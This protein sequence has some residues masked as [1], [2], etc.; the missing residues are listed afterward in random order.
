V[1]IGIAICSIAILSTPSAAPG[2]QVKDNAPAAPCS[3]PEY[4]Q[5]DFF[6]GDWDVSDFDA[7]SRVVAR[8]RATKILDGCVIQEDYRE[9][10]G[11][12][13][14][15]FSLYDSSAGRWHQSWVTN[16]GE[17]ILLDGGLEGDRMVLTGTVTDKA[18]KKSL[19]RGT[20]IPGREGV[21]E[22][23]VSSTDGGKSWTPAFDILLRPRKNAG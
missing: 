17:L 8:L 21:R 10:G 23:A 20:W 19:L 7:P 22:T 4:R 1:K 12:H 18:G 5:F 9:Q 11:H 14:E 6:A 16:R 3:A 15:S 13:G 2:A